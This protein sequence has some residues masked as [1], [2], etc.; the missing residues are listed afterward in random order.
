MAEAET[1]SLVVLSTGLAPTFLTVLVNNI[2]SDFL[3]KN[4]CYGV[5]GQ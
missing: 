5:F 4:H 3:V 1:F 2:V